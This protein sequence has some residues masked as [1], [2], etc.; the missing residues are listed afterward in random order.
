M[1]EHENQEREELPERKKLVIGLGALFL[2]ALYAGGIFK[3]ILTDAGNVSLN[4]LR[5]LF[6]ALFSVTGWKCTFLA[7]LLLL[8]FA[9]LILF[10]SEKGGLAGTD[11]ERNFSYSS[12]GTYGTAGYM[13]DS[14][15]KVVLREDRDVRQVDG[16]I[17]GQDLKTGHVLS[18]P[19]DSRL[20]RN[21]AVCGSQ[22][23]MKS[24]AFARNMI[25][26]CVKRG[27]SM[28]VTDPKS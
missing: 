4:P 13:K 23:S 9:G 19:R 11:E 14:E 24:R 18:L 28:F 1:G 27:E 22:G 15:R 8:V 17:L 6:G 10:R 12:L 25:L 2:L 26:Q 16:I 5:C 20:N 7:L 3:Q 21:I